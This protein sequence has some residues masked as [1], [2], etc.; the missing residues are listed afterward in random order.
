MQD[1]VRTWTDPGPDLLDPV[2]GEPGPG[3][4][5][6]GP[7]LEVRVRGPQNLPGPDPDRTVD[8]VDATT[9]FHYAAFTTLNNTYDGTEG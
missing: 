5:F 6:S 2:W 1:Q 9:S 7:D 3:P 8:S 4:S